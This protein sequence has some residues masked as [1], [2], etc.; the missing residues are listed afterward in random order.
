[1]A[2]QWAA[3]ALAAW[4]VSKVGW[5]EAAEEDF[6]FWYEGLTSEESMEVIGDALEGCLKARGLD[7]IPRLRRVHHR[8]ERP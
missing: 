2:Q 3:P 6:R 4:P 8:V 1:M 7:A 5:D